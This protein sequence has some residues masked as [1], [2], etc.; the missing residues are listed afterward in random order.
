MEQ[1]QE[2]TAGQSPGT[3]TARGQGH[4]RA[5]TWLFVGVA[6]LAVGVH[7]VTPRILGLARFA[8]PNRFPAQ[9]SLSCPA[10][11]QFEPGS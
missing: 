8:R 4:R 5:R 10:V 7:S 3:E 1:E 9:D 6:S 2:R 11:R